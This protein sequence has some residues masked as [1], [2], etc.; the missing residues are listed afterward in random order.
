MLCYWY[1][2]NGYRKQYESETR[3]N[4]EQYES[5]A[6]AN[7]KQSDSKVESDG[8]QGW[9]ERCVMLVFACSNG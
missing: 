3:A 1:N 4:T 6:I 8:E 9:D 5:N 2:A 7:S